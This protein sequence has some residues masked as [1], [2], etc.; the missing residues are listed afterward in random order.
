VDQVDVAATEVLYDDPAK[1]TFDTEQ[2]SHLREVLLRTPPTSEVLLMNAYFVPQERLIDALVAQ[3][4]R[5]VRVR[6]LTNS[7]ASTDVVAIHSGYAKTRAKLLAGD[8]A[9]AQ[10]SY[11][12]LKAADPVA[13]SAEA[14]LDYARALALQGKNDEALAQ[15]RRIMELDSMFQGHVGRAELAHAYLW[16]GRCAESLAALEGRPGGAVP[17]W[18]G[19]L[20]YT[21]ARCGRR[22]QALAELDRLGA[23]A[24][25]GRFVSHL[26]LAMIH[27]GLGDNERALAELDSAY[28]ERAWA[29]FTLRVDPAFDGLRADPRFSRLLKKVG[30]VS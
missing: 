20:G 28:V 17:V 13:F 15:S 21:Y 24:R 9:G 4:S 19:L 3:R 27:A 5:G 2:P 30:L 25:Q 11:E 22:A 10:A 8:G 12:R 18:S 7:L 29:M 1:G 14:E 23:E 16:L 6:V 26:A